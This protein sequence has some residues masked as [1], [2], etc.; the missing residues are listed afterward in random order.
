M[1]SWC[2][3]WMNQDLRHLLVVFQC[4]ILKYLM[5]GLLRH[6][7]KSSIIP[8]S[9]EKLVWRNERPIRGPFLSRKT[10]CLLDLRSLPGHWEPWFCRKLRRPI[11]YCSS[12]WRF[13]GIR[14]EM[15]R[16]FIV[17]DEH[18]TW[19]HLGRIVQIK[20]TRVWKTQDRI[21]IVWLGDSSEEVGTW[22]SQT[23]NDREQKYRARFAKQEFWSQKW[24][25]WEE[26]RG[27]E[28]GNKTAWTKDYSEGDNCSFRH[29]IN[30]RGKITPSKPSPN[31]FTRHNDRK[32]SRTRSPRGQSPSGRMFRWPCKDYLNG[33][34]TDSFCEKCQPPECM[35]HK[36]DDK[37]AVAML[38]EEVWLAW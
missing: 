36:N 24:K 30:K 21:G 38:N 19:S 1:W 34:C 10:D 18:P 20:N 26:R 4:R 2:I 11:H 13:S 12:K 33:T 9:E 8:I 22:L 31:S 35:F 5:R 7:T 14:I 37:S 3:R 6:L 25:F 17:N 16:D 29:N 27:Q 15:G 28:S 32:P 23:E